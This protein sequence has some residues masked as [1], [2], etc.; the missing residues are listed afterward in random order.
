MC[1]T[2][3]GP[4]MSSLADMLRSAIDTRDQA[5]RA[6]GERFTLVHLAE[7]TGIERTTLGRIVKGELRGS[8]ESL[9]ALSRELELDPGAVLVAAAAWSPAS[10]QSAA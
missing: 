7:L 8:V 9:N 10:S 3:T 4:E 5:A 6:R 1:G 2:H